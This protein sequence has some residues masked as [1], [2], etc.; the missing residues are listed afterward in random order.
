MLMPPATKTRP[1]PT[2]AVTT[3]AAHNQDHALDTLAG[4]FEYTVNPL[5]EMCLNDGA[6]QAQVLQVIAQ[7]GWQP[8]QPPA[9]LILN[10]GLGM[11]TGRTNT[12]NRQTNSTGTGARSSGSSG[13]SGKSTARRRTTKPAAGL[14][15]T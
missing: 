9:G 2:G 5:I 1:T 13:G 7:Q 11:G 12:R 14:G 10:N 6:S 15:V 4:V 8:I 3:S